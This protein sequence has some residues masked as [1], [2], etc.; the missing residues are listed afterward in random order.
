MVQ[1]YHY[2]QLD[3][4]PSDQLQNKMVSG[5]KTIQVHRDDQPGV[6]GRETAQADC[7]DMERVAGEKKIIAS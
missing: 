6:C 3:D 4:K 7:M 1:A 2:D 5:I